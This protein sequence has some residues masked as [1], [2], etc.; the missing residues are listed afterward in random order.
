MPMAERIHAD[1]G[2][3]VQVAGAIG[4]KQPATIASLEDDGIA[5]VD[6]QQALRFVGDD[7][8]G[9]S[10]DAHIVSNACVRTIRVPAAALKSLMPLPAMMATRP[11]P[12][13]S[14]MRQAVSL[15]TIP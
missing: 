10:G 6:L 5:A 12:A 7:V 1:P 14:A 3:Q 4:G 9:D 15:A 11:T 13:S 8:G 2:D